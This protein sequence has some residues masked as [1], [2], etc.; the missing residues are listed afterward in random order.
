MDKSKKIFFKGYMSFD[1]ILEA[2]TY[3]DMAF[4]YKGRRYNIS[5]SEKPCIAV[6]DETVQVWKDTVKRYDT[7]EELLLTHVFDDGVKLID[8]LVN[9]VTP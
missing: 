9:D 5:I 6:C 4:T 3:G 2:I 8:A 7:Y 1:E